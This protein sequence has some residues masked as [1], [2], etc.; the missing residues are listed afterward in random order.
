MSCCVEPANNTTVTRS[1][2]YYPL[3]THPNLKCI[4]G[5]VIS[6]R[7]ILP[8]YFESNSFVYSVNLDV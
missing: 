1:Y 5:Y 3:L 8:M 7:H 6:S 4:L 2:E